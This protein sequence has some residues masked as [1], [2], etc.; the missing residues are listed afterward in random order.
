MTVGEYLARIT[1]YGFAGSC[2]VGRGEE[3]ELAEGYGHAVRAT[4]AANTA[5]TVHALGSLTKQFTAAA[6]LKLEEQGRLA[7]SDPVTRF[8]DVPEDKTG[9]SLHHLLTHTS[10]LLPDTGPDFEPCTRDEA[11]ERML[12]APLLFPPGEGQSYSNAGFSLLAAVVELVSGRD[13]EDY[14]RGE[15]LEPAGLA[16]TG[17]RL[18]DWGAAT[19]A[20]WYT[21]SAEW[22][23]PLEK[24]YPCWNILGNGDVLSTAPDMWRWLVALRTGS[25]L[26]E[27]SRAKL[28]TASAGDFGYGWRVTSGPYGEV[29]AHGGASTDG[30]SAMLSWY[31]DADVAV[32]LLCNR[33]FAGAPLAHI[34][35]DRVAGAAFG[36]EV[37]VPPRAEPT[38]PPWPEGE[39]GLRGGGSIGLE[40]P[41][42]ELCAV[43]R[44]QEAVDLLAWGGAS[45]AALNE[46][47]RELV[48]AALAGDL[49]PLQ[50][51]AD[52]GPDRVARFRRLFEPHAGS[53]PGTALTAPAH[54][55]GAAETRVAL[56]DGEAVSLYWRDGGLL[57]AAPSEQPSQLVLPL[58]RAGE[59]FAAYHL[60]SERFAELEL[61]DGRL[62]VYA[63]G[64]STTA[65]PKG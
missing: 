41:A 24:P 49:S 9:I 58:A 50:R 21:D 18:P 39:F 40:S 11:L 46:R 65:T 53:E 56:T 48:A 10:G 23:T 31:R 30:V 54:V 38:G 26:G 19:V 20:H 1:P 37:T 51:E 55:P 63:G 47:A 43:A 12:A 7:T 44:G 4:G 13:Y 61:A 25:I 34:V 57:G 6:I 32:V 33:M 62:V 5:D 42:G 8:V 14:L 16:S 36:D 15:L 3:V 27:R 59:R 22:G 28:F 45:H 60:G 2:L 52:A 17:F 64:R 35:S 29:V